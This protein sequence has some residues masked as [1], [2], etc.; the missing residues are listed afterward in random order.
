MSVVVATALPA[1]DHRDAVIAA[2]ER[3][4]ESVHPNDE[5]CELNLQVLTPYAA[6]TP[7]PGRL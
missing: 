3:A 2:F 7:A 4:I 5:G 1:A 6:G